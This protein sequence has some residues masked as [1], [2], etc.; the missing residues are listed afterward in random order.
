MYIRLVFLL[1]LISQLL[2]F[3]GVFAEKVREDSSGENTINWE[4]IEENKSKPYKKI[5]WRS[6]KND[7][8][9][10]GNE[11]QQSSIIQKTK[12]SNEEK[13]SESSKK[14][15][16]SITE[17][18]PYLPLNN[19]LEYGNFK[20]SANWKSSFGGAWQVATGK[21]NED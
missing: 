21:H 20:T 16:T 19:F 6:Y 10:F 15:G 8:S 17:I 5:I 14:L 2:N 12:S 9:Y 7:E 13:I 18:E 1:F 11:K 3:I 4:K